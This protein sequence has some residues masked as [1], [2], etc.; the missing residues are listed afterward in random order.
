MADEAK[1]MGFLPQQPLYLAVSRPLARPASSVPDSVFLSIWS[2]GA[3]RDAVAAW[4]AEQ[5][6]EELAEPAT[7]IAH[8]P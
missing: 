3:G 7:S 6:P 2:V 1:G 4:P 5:G 8:L